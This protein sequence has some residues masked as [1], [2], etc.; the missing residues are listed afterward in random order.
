MLCILEC[1]R[2]VFCIKYR[3]M[4]SLLLDIVS[5]W[6]NAHIA[7]PDD[8]NSLGDH[9]WTHVKGMIEPLCI[10]EDIL[11]SM[12]DIRQETLDEESSEEDE[13]VEWAIENICVW[14]ND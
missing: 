8:P 5:I 6:E 3:M 9:G 14:D 11:S 12:V 2:F 13:D 7:Q 10:Q 1:C 4:I